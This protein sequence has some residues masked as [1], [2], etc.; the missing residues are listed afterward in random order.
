MVDITSVRSYAL[1]VTRDPIYEKIGALI[2]DRRK[3]LNLKQENLATMLGISRGSLANIEIGRQ[4]VLV[5]QLYRFAEALQ[6]SPFDLLPQPKPHS[7][8]KGVQLP[9]PDDLKAKQRQEVEE[10]FAQIDTSETA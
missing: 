5:H 9:L 10:F 2:R 1:K 8:S 6:L 7:R 3:S 4:G